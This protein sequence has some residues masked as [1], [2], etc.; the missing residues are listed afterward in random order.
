MFGKRLFGNCD[1]RLCLGAT[2]T[3]T[4]EYFSSLI[5]VSTIENISIK[6]ANGI[7]GEL[8]YGQKNIS[9]LKRNLINPDEILRLPNDKLIVNLRGNKPLLL[10]KMIYTE[11]P[12]SKN[13]K[14]NSINEYNPKWNKKEVI[15]SAVNKKAN[16]KNK[17]KSRK[18]NKNPKITF[19]DF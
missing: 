14:Q 18:E 19:D 8:E 5:G 3:L 13:L 6:K 12:L 2:D 10:E 11:H 7:D 4:A 15:N 9:T 1:T 17:E 16:I